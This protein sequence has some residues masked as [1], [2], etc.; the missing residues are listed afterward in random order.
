[1]EKEDHLDKETSVSAEL[2]PSGGVKASA[3]S[4]AVAAFDRLIGNVF[5][6]W[7]APMEAKT[8]ET[9]A[10]SA[11]RLKVIEAVTV[12][13]L[14]KLRDDPE[15][16]ARAVENHFGKILDRQDNKEA[17]VAAA[18]EDL[19]EQP[20][21]D[22]EAS[23]GGEQLQ[24]PFM[25][26]FERFAE[27]ATTDDLREKWGRVLAAEIRKPGTFSAKVMRVIDELDPVAAALFEKVCASRV[28]TVLPKATLGI[29]DFSDTVKL[30]EA[31]L[32]VE[33]GLGQIRNFQEIV[34][35]SGVAIWYGYFGIFGIG[36]PKNEV[37]MWTND[38]IQQQGSVPAIPVY[39][40]TDVGFAISSIL[41][42]TESQAF[43]KLCR[44][45]EEK[46]QEGSH[47]RKYGQITNGQFA[48][49]T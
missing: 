1:M 12:L 14:D 42:N 2:T 44:K 3:R 22:E 48:P 41:A 10:V 15:A 6:K 25:N 8:A 5:E 47:L 45:L 24:G 30:T 18:V 4:R 36:F 33:P 39:V 9:R 17:V 11:S 35:S 16:A 34:D 40:L 21:T 20:P 37:V 49:I 13:G 19:R 7:N 46:L 43:S 29:L 38:V 32:I 31:G 28:H 26:R 23:S 27:E